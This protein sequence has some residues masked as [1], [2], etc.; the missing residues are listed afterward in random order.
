MKNILVAVTLATTIVTVQ[1]DAASD[2]LC[3]TAK[4]SLDVANNLKI[5][6]GID[7]AKK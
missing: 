1:A 4:A 5:Q 6:A 2:A 3:T 7:A